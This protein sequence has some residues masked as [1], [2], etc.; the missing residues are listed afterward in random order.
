VI[1]DIDPDVFAADANLD[2]DYAAAAV[3]AD[4]SADVA[5]DVAVETIFLESQTDNTYHYQN[6]ATVV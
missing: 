5:A 2:K 4:V 6:I 1:H 3:S